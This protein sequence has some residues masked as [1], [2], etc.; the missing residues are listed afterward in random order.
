MSYYTRMTPITKIL[1]LA[2]P[3]PLVRLFDYDA[4]QVVD[5]DQLTAGIRVQVPFQSR[6]LTGWLIEKTDTSTLPPHKLKPIIA[7]IDH[8]PPLP[9]E[10]Y[11]LCLWA[12][13]YYHGSLGDILTQTLPPSL[14][15]QSLESVLSATSLSP[16]NTPLQINF[17]LNTLQQQACEAVLKK[18]DQFGVFLLDGVTGSGKTAVYLHII[19]AIIAAQKQ[20]LLLVPEISLTPQMVERFQT[21]FNVPMSVLHSGLTA[22]ERL[23]ASAIFR[24]ASSCPTIRSLRCS[25]MRESFSAS[26]SSILDTGTCV[27]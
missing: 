11:Q 18:R 13:R 15:N 2:L 23:T 16:L 27:H 1:R 10:L 21:H 9:N 20:V 12:A 17:A 3:T 19:H 6:T 4:T 25:S 5:Y 24:T 14:R 26:S 7:I 8:V 22:R